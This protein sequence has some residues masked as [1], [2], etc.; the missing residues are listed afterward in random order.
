MQR[1][2]T[3]SGVDL[4]A[5]ADMVAGRVAA[6]MRA[7]AERLLTLDDLADR[8][9]LSARGVRGLVTRGELP[10]GLLIGGCRRWSWAVVQSFLDAGATRKTRR[11]RRGQ[12]DRTT[13]DHASS[14]GD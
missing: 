2:N 13:A 14:E 3:E 9:Q 8:L 5:L 4:E 11:R 1:L 7:D 10:A 6:A 12:Y